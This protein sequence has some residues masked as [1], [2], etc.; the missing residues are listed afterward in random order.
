MFKKR[1]MSLML[2]SCAALMACQPAGANQDK[3]LMEG[4]DGKTAE[5]PLDAN[6][7]AAK[8]FL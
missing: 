6:G 5:A 8:E 4:V 7:Q 2:I 1:L 3:S